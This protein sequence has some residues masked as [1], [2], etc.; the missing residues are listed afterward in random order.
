MEV[1]NQNNFLAPVVE[2]EVPELPRRKSVAT[3]RIY[4]SQRPAFSLIYKADTLEGVKSGYR[5]LILCC[6]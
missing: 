5:T 3:W 4:G 2:T 1:Q 6:G